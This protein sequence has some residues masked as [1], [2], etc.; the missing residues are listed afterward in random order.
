MG[1]SIG[2]KYGLIIFF[3]SILLPVLVITSWFYGTKT[4]NLTE[5]TLTESL[6]FVLKAKE[7]QIAVIQVQQLL[8][9]ISATKNEQG[10]DE[11]KT[12][13]SQFI[14]L[15]NEFLEIYT[16]ENNQKAIEEIKKLNKDFNAFHEMGK[17]MA[18]AYITGGAA[19]GNKIMAKFDPYAKSI[20]VNTTSFLQNHID[21][22]KENM[23]SISSIVNKSRNINL[24]LGIAIY[25][26]LLISV[27]LITGV[28]KRNIISIKTFTDTM[29]KG[30][31]ANSLGAGN[32]EDIGQISNQ[33][34]VLKSETS[35]VLIDINN[36]I[37]TLNTSSNNLYAIS[38]K[39]K[40]G[41]ELNC[42]LASNAAKDS[43]T[44]SDNM[45]SVA[46]ASE[47]VSTN[48]NMVASSAEEMSVTINEIAKN[49]ESARVITDRAVSQ[50]QLASTKVDELGEV[51]ADIN[52][53]TETI[54]E[55]SDQT[56]LLALNAT[57]EAAR[58]GEAG[59]GFAVVA[60]EIK[61]LA[62]QTS[63][64][65]NEI[66]EKVNAIQTSSM[67]TISMIKEINQIN[68]QVN[69]I[70]TIIANAV[71]EQSV[72]TQEIASNISQASEGIQ[73][74]NKNMAQ[75]SALAGNISKDVSGVHSSSNEMAINSFE[76]NISLYELQKLAQ[77][78]KGVMEKFRLKDSLFD[79]AA[80]KSAHLQWRIKLESL[81]H[82][83][84]TLKTEEVSNHHQCDFGKWYDG[85]EGQ[86]LKG[87][88]EYVIVGDHHKKV[89][90]IARRVVEMVNKGDKKQASLLITEFEKERGK[91]LE[92]LNDLYL[93]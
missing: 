51:A 24:I 22:L 38:E 7:M 83:K 67:D 65:T 32:N 69:E 31:Y 71:E 19:E 13:A 9:D 12:Y 68:K 66:K 93:C 49:T 92:S 61:E 30:D 26:A 43:E 17:T 82:G 34:N 87:F 29:A 5:K 78:L 88:P 54:T 85:P 18:N 40:Q 6:V 74:V 42:E 44:V 20:T 11:A 48:I 45:T 39:L 60:N 91:L 46:A 57:I 23:N 53:V 16:R 15:S 86:K 64:A 80:V 27:F 77:R 8:T 10:Y 36:G 81:L 79:I 63:E 62:R 3:I 55:I 75:C 90:S 76:V 59:K 50:T 37:S 47:Q 35:K 58:A 1:T 28:I 25:I 2:K 21:K 14:N 89:H 4:K 73:E 56:N 84:E 41:A 72:T 52:K 70:V 33:L